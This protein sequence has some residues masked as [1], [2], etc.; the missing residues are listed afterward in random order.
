MMSRLR[1]S[2]GRRILAA[3]MFAAL[4]AAACPAQAGPTPGSSWVFRRSYYSHDPVQPVRIGRRSAGGPF[5][6]SPQ[7]GYVR[8]GY[9]NIQSTINVGGQQYDHIGIWE[10]W[11]QTG[12]Q[13]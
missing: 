6:T 10:S 4:A 1:S 2:F 9:R 8:A 7:G 3:M 12:A 13:Y 11:G 5:Y